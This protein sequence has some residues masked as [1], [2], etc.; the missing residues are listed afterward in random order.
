MLH[1]PGIARS[2]G[3]SYMLRLGGLVSRARAVAQTAYASAV[4]AGGVDG[5]HVVGALTTVVPAWVHSYGRSPSPLLPALPP[6]LS[7]GL[8][9]RPCGLL[10]WWIRLMRQQRR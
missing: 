3:A 5:E 7:S 9:G 6:G 8:S 1:Q 10:P 4:A 2:S